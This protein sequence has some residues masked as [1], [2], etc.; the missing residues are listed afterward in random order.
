MSLEAFPIGSSAM[1]LVWTKP[2]EANGIVTG[3]R[4][5]Y[6][7]VNGSSLEPE[8]ERQ[9]H[10]TNADATSAK[11]PGLI[12]ETKYRIHIRATTRAGEGQK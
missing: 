12:P 9:P 10:V 6:Q 4:I 8:L 3:H 11:L 1:Q 5:Y 2:A 7:V